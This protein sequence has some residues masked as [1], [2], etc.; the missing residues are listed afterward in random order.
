MMS[1]RKLLDLLEKEEIRTLRLNYSQLL[2]SGQIHKMEEV[3]TSDARVEVIVG[4]MNGIEQIKQGLKNAYD[5][6]DTHN[7]KHFPFVHAVMNHQI[8]LTDKT[9]AQGECYLIDFVTSREQSESPLLLV[10]RYLDR[11]EKID[12]Q[13]RISHSKLDVVWPANSGVQ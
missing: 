13:W 4:E 2:D 5:E 12:G 10:G 7:R 9:T 1:E 8:V 11:Y 3:F 6:F